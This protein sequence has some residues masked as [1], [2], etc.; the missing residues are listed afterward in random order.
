[1]IKIIKSSL[2]LPNYL[3]DSILDLEIKT[4]KSAQITHLVFD[5][6]RTLVKRR[7]NVMSP[8]YLKFIKKLKNAGYVIILGSNTR[9]DIDDLSKL[10]GIEV[11]RPKGVAIKPS[12]S[13]YAR[14]ISATHTTPEHIA[15]IG[16]HILN[17]VFGANRAGMT[18]IMVR[19]LHHKTSLLKRYY[20]KN[21]LKH[22]G[23]IRSI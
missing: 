8:E 7:T 3:A 18:S 9:R 12:K 17:D 16:D 22:A 20:I 11:V 5:L 4:L 19:P 6:D 1:V 14:L 15:M 23:K 13:F 21:A 10:L 2:W